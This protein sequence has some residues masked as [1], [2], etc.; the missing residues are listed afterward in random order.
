MIR[1]P[2]TIGLLLL[3]VFVLTL[4]PRL[5][6]AARVGAGLSARVT[7]ALAHHSGLDADWIAS[8]YMAA[9]LGPTAPLVSVQ[10][11]A[12]TGRVESRAL[13]FVRKRAIV[14]EGIGCTLVFDDY[15]TRL[16]GFRDPPHADPLPANLPWPL[17]DA[18]LEFS[19]DPAMAVALDEAMDT[20][21]A[22]PENPP[23]QMRQTL[24][25]LIAHGGRLVGERYALSVDED[26]R[27]LSWSA[28][29]SVVA[30]LIGVAELEGRLDR[31]AAATVPEWQGADDPRG[32][33]TVDQL[34]RMSSGLAFNED[35]GTISD[36]SR[37]LFDQPDAGA[38]AADMPLAHEPDTAWSYSSGTSNILTRI[39]RDLFKRDL[40]ALVLWS[41]RSLFDPIGMRSAVFETD[42]SGS[43]VGSSLFFATGR[44]WLRFGQLHLQDGF[45]NGKRVLPTGWSRY[46]STPTPQAPQG[47]YGAG[48]WLNAGDPDDPSDRMWPTLP[49]EVYAARGMSGQYVVIVPSEELVI[50]RFGLTHAESDE[51]QG[52]EELVRAVIDAVRSPRPSRLPT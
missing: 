4:W 7:C 26:S 2:K 27:L 10:R 22:E 20:A 30:A 33:I 9:L 49:R 38:F 41:R 42:A 31:F 51:F 28:A 8:H 40:E 52:I 13:H 5:H 17:G 48:W 19:M 1:R 18:P 46:V 37:M 3:V 29:K 11:D 14:R 12:D 43:F 21:F 35:Y 50:V 45:W 32:T 36:V 34:L 39:L 44:D 25:V 15:E 47:G 6:T 24:A 23:G 16:M